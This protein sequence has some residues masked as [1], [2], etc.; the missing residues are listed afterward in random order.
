[1][2]TK[3]DTRTDSRLAARCAAIA[4]AGAAVIHFAVVPMH[5]A[6]WLPSGVFFASI[7]LLQ[8]L[9]VVL[10]WSCPTPVV[11]AIGIAANAGAVALWIESRTTGAPFGP[12]AGQPE[13]VDAA[14][15]CVLLLQCYV[16]MGAA[17]AWMRRSR[18][19]QVSGPGR[20][21]VL[22]GAN[23]VMAAAVTAGLASTLY[24]HS[25]HHHGPAEAHDAQQVTRG[26][27]APEHHHPPVPAAVPLEGAT[28]GPAP[29][30]AGPGLPMVESSLHTDDH[31]AHHD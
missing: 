28:T 20:A 2:S 19:G 10:V 16:V 27:P 12:A 25:P 4:S 30:P 22:V 8:L 3:A 7:A 5:W 23:V 17:W 6:D 31:P 24:G 1:M 29:A 14:G 13:A 18:A 26:V 15:I 21:L 11:F 9:W